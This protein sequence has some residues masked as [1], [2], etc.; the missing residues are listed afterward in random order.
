MQHLV[1]IAIHTL[2]VVSSLTI[3]SFLAYSAAEKTEKTTTNK[4]L[5][6][7]MVELIQDTRCATSKLPLDTTIVANQES[8]QSTYNQPVTVD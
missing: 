8:N 6:A 1:K 2:L 7:Y 3:S 4:A 5:P